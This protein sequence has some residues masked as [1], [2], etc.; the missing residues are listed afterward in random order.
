MSSAT[1]VRK[2]YA[3]AGSARIDVVMQYAPVGT[4]IAFAVGR[5]NVVDPLG[6]SARRSRRFMLDTAFFWSPCRIPVYDD[7]YQQLSCR[8][9][10]AHHGRLVLCR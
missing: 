3:N 4:E 2:L 1:G 10:A 6:D 8:H 5:R 9:D 7:S